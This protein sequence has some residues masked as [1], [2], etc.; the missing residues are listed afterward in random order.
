LFFIW[1]FNLFNGSASGFSTKFYHAR[2]FY[3]SIT[4]FTKLYG[5]FTDAAQIIDEQTLV[6]QFVGVF[7]LLVTVETSPCGIHTTH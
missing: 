3:Y 7:D 1:T 4:A 6:Y 2:A 5:D